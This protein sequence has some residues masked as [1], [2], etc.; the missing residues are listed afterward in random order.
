[1]VKTKL[2][3]DTMESAQ[4]EIRKVTRRKGKSKAYLGEAADKPYL[5]KMTDPSDI[6]KAIHGK[7]HLTDTPK[8]GE[9]IE[10]KPGEMPQLDKLLAEGGVKY[11]NDVPN[12]AKILKDHPY[13][14]EITPLSEMVGTKKK[15][16]IIIEEVQTPPEMGMPPNPT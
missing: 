3:D 5:G 6:A 4:N 9:M 7:K 14:G 1:M 13:A 12:F 15:K 16:V 10:G 2:I 11:G 8:L